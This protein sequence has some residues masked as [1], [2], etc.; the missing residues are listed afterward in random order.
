MLTTRLRR[1]A[2]NSLG[3]VAGDRL[4]YRLLHA[5]LHLKNGQLPRFM[6]LDRPVT[7]ND[8]INYLKLHQRIP[9][10]HLLV[11]KYAVKEYVARRIGVEHVVPTVG[12]YESADEV[13]MSALPERCVLKPTHA[14]GFC[15][16]YNAQCRPDVATMRRTMRAWLKTDY[17]R[18]GRE[19][20]Y[21]GI[22]PRILAETYLGDS[23]G[24]P[25]YD[26]KFFCFNGVP[27]LVQVDIDRFSDHT[28]IFYDL[29]WR[30]QPFSLLYPASSRE[31]P[32]P[33][34]LDTMVEIAGTLADGFPFMRVDLYSTCH[35]VYFGELT[36]HPDGGYGPF[37]PPEYDVL[38]GEMLDLSGFTAR[39]CRLVPANSTE[40]D[41][42]GVESFR[43]DSGCQMT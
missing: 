36:F 12:V 4:F 38:L 11:D 26:Y 33:R 27:R 32:R 23:Q 17:H 2:Y 31:I 7:F 30:K 19:W 20:Q 39:A 1:W 18:L 6:N 37:A 9:N 28:R 42:I 16:L 14:S 43:P 29:N 25:P 35:G 40:H 5:Y 34:T 3:C 41:A 10:G 13:E 15:L 21:R 22:K 24:Q 8:K